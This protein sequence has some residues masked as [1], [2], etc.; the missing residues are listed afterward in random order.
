[1]Q[2]TKVLIAVD[3]STFSIGAAKAG[4]ELAHQLKATVGLAFVID[5]SKEIINTDLGITLQQSATALL[6]Q[7]E[8]TIEQLI[9]M[10]NDN[11]KAEVLRFTP[12]GFPKK[13]ILNIAK[14]W[15][16]ELIIMGTHGRTGLSHMLVGSVAEYVIKNADV[17]VLVVPFRKSVPK[18][19]TLH[20]LK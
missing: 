10:Y 2:Y 3:N 5:I 18:N 17:P 16:A 14:E 13:E 4:F 19:V 8:D 1:M 9:Q 6:K 12:E 7:A 15:G 11:G 20:D